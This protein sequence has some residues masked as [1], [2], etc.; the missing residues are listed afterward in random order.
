MSNINQKNVKISFTHVEEAAEGSKDDDKLDD[1]GGESDEAKL[2][3]GGNLLERLLEAEQP[4]EEE[5][6][7]IILQ[8]LQNL[9]NFRI[10]VKTVMDTA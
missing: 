7:S 1:K 6:Y 4:A 3:R 10:D 9:Q 8:I 5:L 2:D